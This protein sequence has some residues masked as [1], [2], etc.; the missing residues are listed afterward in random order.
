MAKVKSIKYLELEFRESLLHYLYGLPTMQI[1]GERS[2]HVR[3]LTDNSRNVRHNYQRDQANYLGHAEIVFQHMVLGELWSK[4]HKLVKIY[5]RYDQ[6]RLYSKVLERVV[7]T[8][9]PEAKIEMVYGE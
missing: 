6:N 1:D 5:E 2:V 9:I 4:P 3:R 7:R 8:Y